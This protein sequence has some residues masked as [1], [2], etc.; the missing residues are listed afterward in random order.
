KKL[1][2]STDRLSAIFSKPPSDG[3]IHIVIENTGNAPECKPHQ[4]HA[5]D[6]DTTPNS[7]ALLS[8]W[9]IET[10]QLGYVPPVKSSVS[11]QV[12]QQF[13]RET[14]TVLKSGMGPFEDKSPQDVNF[15]AQDPCP[16]AV[17]FSETGKHD[18]PVNST[19][20]GEASQQGGQGAPNL[21]DVVVV[22]T[23]KLKRT[24]SFMEENTGDTPEQD[25]IPC[26]YHPASSTTRVCFPPR[27][28]RHN[29]L[30]AS[31]A[32]D[33]AGA[34]NEQGT[35]ESSNPAAARKLRRITA[36]MDGD[37]GSSPEQYSTSSTEKICFT[38][39]ERRESSER[40]HL[41]HQ[42]QEA[43]RRLNRVKRR[44]TLDLLQNSIELYGPAREQVSHSMLND[45]EKIAKV[46]R[47]HLRDYND[48][49]AKINKWLQHTEELD[50]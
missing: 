22:R 13:S 18:Q 11:D 35:P 36:F 12:G 44:A 16:T 9:D 32:A 49:I 14:S 21:S 15:C 20:T 29:H 41:I 40:L 17:I 37:S 3:Y 33:E 45:L 38:D 39:Q 28:D 25:I 42:A 31:T 30:V 7:P 6:E 46:S 27:K 24:F 8:A 48:R 4:D 1:L 50:T 47:R 26:S 23:S 43:I 10:L 5:P 2:M 19:A 34:H